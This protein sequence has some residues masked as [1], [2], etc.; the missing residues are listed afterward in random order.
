MTPEL[1]VYKI[2][3]QGEFTKYQVLHWNLFFLL[4]AEQESDEKGIV[5]EDMTNKEVDSISNTESDIWKLM[6]CILVCR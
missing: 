1:P 6:V 5:P 4:F 3:Q 2:L